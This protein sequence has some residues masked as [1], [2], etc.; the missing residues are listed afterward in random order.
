MRSV[1]SVGLYQFAAMRA[2]VGE[3]LA[4]GA[5]EH[6]AK[7]C[8]PNVCF[9]YDIIIAVKQFHADNALSR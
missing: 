1:F 7:A 5:Y 9:R 6:R 2:F 4:D 8:R 3:R